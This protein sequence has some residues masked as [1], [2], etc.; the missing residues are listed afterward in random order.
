MRE[1][2]SDEWAGRTSN[3]YGLYSRDCANRAEWQESTSH[4]HTVSLDRNSATPTM[5]TVFSAR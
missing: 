1:P 3:T 5:A 4:L 2:H